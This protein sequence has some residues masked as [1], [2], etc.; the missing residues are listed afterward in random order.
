MAVDL[1][2]YDDD[3]TTHHKGAR[4]RR[5]SGPQPAHMRLNIT[6][7]IDVV[8]QL[9]IYFIVTASFAIDEG[10]LTAQLPERGQAI[11][12]G[13]PPEDP[14]RI[15]IASFGEEP[16]AYQI[17]LDRRPIENFRSLG[18]ELI[19][20]QQLPAYSE[21]TPV[22]ISAGPDVRWQHVVNA[23]HASR[24]VAGFLSVGFDPNPR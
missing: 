15:S 14:I 7:M 9:L 12:E 24:R 11:E 5:T 19:S 20:I 2:K 21:E 10:L 3:Q 17:R 18:Q 22:I 4:D 8:F 1:R 16:G 13:P 23:V 6:P